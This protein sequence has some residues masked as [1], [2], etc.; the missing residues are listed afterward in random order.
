MPRVRAIDSPAA[1][2]ALYEAMRPAWEKITDLLGGTPAMRRAA[3]KYL[4]KE[5]LENA[6]A[7]ST[8]LQRSFLYNGLKGGLSK[9]VSYPFG[10]LVEIREKDSLPEYLQPLE[11][12]VDGQG[13][14]LHAFARDFFEAMIALGHAFVFCDWP[15]MS[16]V[17]DESGAIS[18]A[19]EAEAGARVMW[20]LIKATDMIGWQHSQ[21]GKLE[22]IRFREVRVEKQEGKRWLDEE[23][24]YIR[25]IRAD[26]TWEEWRSSTPLREGETILGTYLGTKPFAPISADVAK[27]KQI[28]TGTHTF[29]GIP[30]VVGYAN[31]TGE[32]CSEPPLLELAETNIEHWQS[33]SDQRNILRFARLAQKVATGVSPKDAESDNMKASV[34]NVI[35]LKDPAA[36]MYYLEHSGAGIQAGRDDLKDLE[37]HM[38][39]QGL[40]P[41]VQVSIDQT[42][43]GSMIDLMNVTSDTQAWVMEED[44]VLLKAYEIS[45]ELH[46]G[47][48]EL[49]EGAKPKI[50]DDFSVPS[51][52]V[53]DFPHVMALKD[54]G[55]IRKVTAL[56]EAQRR[57]IVSMTIDAE[58]EV[59]KAQEEAAAAMPVGAPGQPG[60]GEATLAPGGEDGH[61]HS[62]S[63]DAASNGTSSPGPDGHVHQVVAGE[64]Q[65]A[66]NPPHDHAIALPEAV[67]EDDEEEED[68]DAPPFGKKPGASGKPPFGA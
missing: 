14:S 5:P 60:S 27:F 10:K 42:A 50:Y 43:T 31:K 58:E 48:G 7:Y 63:L 36:N 52:A 20:K 8:R 38:R 4:P 39:G 21:S 41:L 11:D 23:R 30:I 18:K 29:D 24:E 46:G 62:A 54:G 53:Q 49:P 45:D 57:S 9:I 6:R 64:V 34:H 16:A 26:G 47:T 12:D 3:Q 56:K 33:N 13:T 32:F 35:T 66:G 22:E 2:C 59:E 40:Q 55:M 61:T 19:A 37:E 17:A 15:D 25:V 28:R 65:P 44:Q 51:G 67:P 68:E 1:P